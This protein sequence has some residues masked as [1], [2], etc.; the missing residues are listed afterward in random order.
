MKKIIPFLAAIFVIIG[1]VLR[2][3]PHFPNFAP[4]AAM[5]LFGGVYLS[6]KYALI[7][8]LVA[9]FV[10]DLFIGFYD[11]KLMAGVYLSFLLIGLIGLFVKKHKNIST[12][13]GGTILGSVLFFVITNFAVWVF[14]NWYPHTLA[15]LGQCFAMAIP[16]FKG[17]LMGD[18]FYVAILFGIYETIM[19]VAKKKQLVIEKN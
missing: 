19:A 14:Y 12:I 2:F 6:K 7:V 5:A 9:M 16:F 3:A 10:S 1:A 4:I 15:G 11:V 18:L 13:I 17:T 8:P